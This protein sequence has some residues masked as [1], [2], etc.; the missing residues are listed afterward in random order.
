MKL[1]EG[2]KALIFG[3]ANNRSIAWG[4][5]KAFHD[6]GATLGFSY[7]IPQ[8]EKRVKPLAAELGVEFVEMC[9]VTS[10]EQVD[11][12]FAKVQAHFGTIDILVH[13]IAF[14]NQSD[15]EGRFVSK[16]QLIGYVVEPR[17]QVTARVAL[18][19]DDIAVFRQETRGVEVMLAG[20]GA[21]PVPAKIRR[22]IPGASQQLPTAAL[23][24]A[25]GGPI[26]VDPRD[27]K[28][29][30]ALNQIFQIE[31]MLPV[32]VRTDY[33]GARVFVRFDHGYE[34]VGIQIYRAFRRL[35]LRQFS[36]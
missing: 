9:N 27:Q 29:V 34:P 32:E 36:V 15:L 7:A 20:W 10:D 35:L 24:T 2:K 30:T 11:E 23:G 4:I 26:L 25:G 3:V 31:L 19:Q 8:L 5:A 21:S 18:L 12:T 14:A 6:H 13:A 1:L 22:E 16:G 17:Q 28:G 33:L